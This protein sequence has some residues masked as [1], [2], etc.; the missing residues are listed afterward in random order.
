MDAPRTQ[1]R[2]NTVGLRIRADAHA[3]RNRPMRDAGQPSRGIYVKS[4]TIHL[5]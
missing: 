4:A 1:Y 5:P 3:V 2:R